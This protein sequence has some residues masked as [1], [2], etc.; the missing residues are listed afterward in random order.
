[1]RNIIN[2]KRNGIAVDNNHSKEDM[3]MKK[4]TKTALGIGV[5]SAAA[6][7]AGIL[8]S[9]APVFAEETGEC[10]C[11]VEEHKADCACGCGEAAKVTEQ[12]QAAY[13][14][15]KAEKDKAQATADEAG[16]KAEEDKSTYDKAMAAESKAIE[17]VK[18]QKADDEKNAL[19]NLT[20]ANVKEGQ[21][22][23]AANDAQTEA[24]AAKSELDKAKGYRDGTLPIEETDEYKAAQ[25]TQ[26]VLDNKAAEKNA[27]DES[28]KAAREDAKEKTEA[29]EKAAADEDAAQKVL[30]EKTEKEDTAAKAAE[31]AKS[32]HDADTAALKTAAEEKAAAK[33]DVTDKTAGK[34]AAE[35]AQQ[36]KAGASNDAAVKET[37]AQQKD[38]Q[39]KAALEDYK[40]E[41]EKKYNSYA[42]FK[43][44]SENTDVSAAVREDA[45]LAA[46]LL[47]N[48]LTENDKKG[49]VSQGN[50]ITYE[51]LIKYTAI[52]DQNDAT[53]LDNLIKS[54][55]WIEQG[56]AHRAEEAD[57]KLALTVSSK[58]M[59]ISEADVN[60]LA[61]RYYAGE[62]IGSHTNVFASLDNLAYELGQLVQNGKPYDPKEP[63]D[64]YSGWYYA[65]KHNYETQ[66][67]GDTGHYLALVGNHQS[68]GYAFLNNYEDIEEDLRPYFPNMFYEYSVHNQSF[69]DD[70]GLSVSEYR[71]LVNSYKNEITAKQAELQAAYDSAHAEYESAKKAA[72]DALAAKEAADKAAQDAAAALATAKENLPGK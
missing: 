40:K 51:D 32:E 14:S 34:E 41:V 35:K 13:D 42:F 65:E 6:V 5:A 22:E 66:N 49:F 18:K 20:E 33:K 16:R 9:A 56:N 55:D 25:V 4:R 54:L 64:P 23:T 62:G 60:Y 1:M 28:L 50:S 37:A 11:T 3:D 21:A 48:E 31:N 29:L 53:H 58:H 30:A 57:P 19:D 7:A 63:F 10:T 47:N 36:E 43:W 71:E 59:A 52:G 8:L 12:K 39:A 68:T 70:A 67:G 72:A 26:T 44:L 27:S 24:D 61:K 45:A 46:R 15:V 38:A 17:D 69:G 2:M